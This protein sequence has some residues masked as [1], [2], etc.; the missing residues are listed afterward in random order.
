[1]S[2]I[3]IEAD[4]DVSLS[5]ILFKGKPL[6]AWQDDFTVNVTPGNTGI[7]MQN[8]IAT[9]NNKYHLAYNCYNELLIVYSNL[10]K[11]F[12]VK[13][14]IVIKGLIDQW[15]VDGV[16]GRTPAKEVLSEMAVSN[17]NDLKALN[18]QLLMVELIKTFFE[19]NKIKLEKTMQL[20]INL[21]FMVSSSEKI[22]HKSGEP[23]LQ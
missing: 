20:I 2:N 3:N 9:L 11:K 1:M 13:K 6:S 19:N 14:G 17:N 4:S 15:K 10:E 5:S 16:S 23:F 18:S 22:H 21:S 8:I 7:E 12:N